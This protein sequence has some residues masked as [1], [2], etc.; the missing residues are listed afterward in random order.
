MID[1]SLPNPLYVVF[2]RICGI[3]DMGADKLGAAMQ[4][5][6]DVCKGVTGPAVHSVHSSV[7]GRMVCVKD[8]V[9]ALQVAENVLDQAARQGVKL[10][11]GLSMGRLDRFDD[12]GRENM[13]GL[14]INLAARLA[15]MDAAECK[16]VLSREVYDQAAQISEHPGSAFVGPNDG[17]VKR[18][19]FAHYLLE[20]SPSGLGNLPERVENGALKGLDSL[21]GAVM[22]PL[23]KRGSQPTAAEYRTV[24]ADAVVYDIAHFSEKSPDEQWM[25]VTALNK[26]VTEVLNSINATHLVN[27]HK[28]WHSPAG[29]GGVLVFGEGAG[30][31]AWMFAKQLALHCRHASVQIR[32][33]VAHGQTVI[34]GSDLPVGAAILRADALSAYPETWHHC[35]DRTFWD[36]RTEADRSEWFARSHDDDSEALLLIPQGERGGDEHAKAPDASILDLCP[37]CLAQVK[38]SAETPA[39]KDFLASG[40]DED[41]MCK[42]RNDGATEALYCIIGALQASF[43]GRPSEA[44][45]KPLL[46]RLAPLTIPANVVRDGR[47][48]LQVD[49]AKRDFRGGVLT[50]SNNT[51]E[52]ADA[53]LRAALYDLPCQWSD[54]SF[55]AGSWPKGEKTINVADVPTRGTPVPDQINDLRRRLLQACQANDLETAKDSMRTWLSI[56]FPLSVLCNEEVVRLLESVGG[57]EELALYLS[58]C[59]KTHSGTR[60][61]LEQLSVI[62]G[63]LKSA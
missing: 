55:A 51:D 11:V 36:L 38:K 12:L 18:T 17:Q 16:I 53:I 15:A 60:T 35:V 30:D 21:P 58:K 49:P 48:L 57:V 59:E 2:C 14:P 45:M 63:L 27:D 42:L 25:V 31:T 9:P 19:R 52:G 4:V 41:F 20:Q 33:G 23:P 29:D 3:K 50:I 43:Y 46:A 39:L 28:L 5:L 56:G 47:K 54:A 34:I 44:A 26:A 37:R 32:L 13:V 1:D 40:A 6:A 22:R 8:V 7:Y 61:V 24:G 10:A 62:A